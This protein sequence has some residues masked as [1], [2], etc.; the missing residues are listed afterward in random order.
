MNKKQQAKL[1]SKI[2]QAA[3]LISKQG[4]IGYADH[5]ILSESAAEN[6]KRAAID[7][8]RECLRKERIEKLKKLFPEE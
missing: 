4:R 8:E 7:W 3:N 5:I 2:N 6:L 1:V